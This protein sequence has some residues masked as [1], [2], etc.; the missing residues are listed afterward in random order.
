MNIMNVTGFAKNDK[1]YSRNLLNK[2]FRDGFLIYNNIFAIHTKYVCV[3]GVY[4]EK[5]ETVYREYSRN[6]SF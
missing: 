4:D 5:I 2:E 1:M 6:N 3:H